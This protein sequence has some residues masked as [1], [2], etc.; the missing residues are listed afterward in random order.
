MTPDEAKLLLQKKCPDC[1]GIQRSESSA[2]NF[3][4]QHKFLAHVPLDVPVQAHI[5]APVESLTT[6][7]LAR[8]LPH[9]TF[10]IAF[11]KDKQFVAVILDQ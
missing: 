1:A 4:G 7:N 5:P 8:H 6:T 10:Q 11:R 2:H 9:F 3:T